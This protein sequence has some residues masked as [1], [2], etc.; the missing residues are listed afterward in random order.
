MHGVNDQI[1]CTV[2]VT[3]GKV[4]S[5]TCWQGMLGD[6]TNWLVTLVCVVSGGYRLGPARQVKSIQ[7]FCV[8]KK[9]LVSQ[10]HNKRAIYNNQLDIM[11][12]NQGYCRVDQT[13]G[14]SDSYIKLQNIVSKIYC[15]LAVCQQVCRLLTKY[16]HIDCINPN[17]SGLMVSIRMTASVDRTR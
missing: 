17:E 2:C 3:Q 12:K 9:T 7:G 8:T 16:L 11:L 4:Y 10:K 14:I 15:S 1:I 13:A 6:Q 5:V